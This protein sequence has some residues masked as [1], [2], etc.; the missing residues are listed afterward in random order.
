MADD[1]SLLFRLRGDA[2]GIRTATS[3][4]RAA[5]NQLKQSFGPEL[6]QSVTLA[7]KAFAG[8]SDNLNAF[9]SQRIPLVGNAFASVTQGL[10][11]LGKESASSERAIAGIAKSIQS[12]ATESG[13]SIPH[14]TSFL[15]K[16]VQIEG[17][18][19]RDKAAIDF[20]GASL[21]TKLVP[22]LEKTGAA[23]ATVST[24]SAGA[25]SAIAAIAGP[26][27]IAVLAFAALAAGAVIL[28]KEL[29]AAAKST[30]EFQ[31][32]LFDLSQQT[33]VSVET[34]SALELVARTTGSSVDALAQ[35]LGIFQ[36]KLEE[37]Q[38]PASKAAKTFRQ[39]GVETD[40]TE[41]SLRQAIAALARM[42]EGFRQ[43][44][45]ALEIFGRG[46]KAFLAI[47]KEA[48]G[49]IDE[50]TRRLKGLGLVTTEEAKLAD[51][52]NDQL[53]LLDIQMRGL[54]TEAIPVILDL[55]KDLSQGLKE[56]RDAFLVLQGVVKGLTLGIVVPLRIALVGLRT[57][58]DK[59][60][61]AIEIQV[62]LFERL[63]KAIGLIS[64]RSFTFP[65][66]S[67]PESPITTPAPQERKDTFA[68]ELN[69]EI[70]ARRKLQ[71]VL[72]FQFALRQQQAKNNIAA[73]QREFEAGKR[74]SE[75]L[76]EVI[77]TNTRKQVQAQIDQLEV[78]RGL[79]LK[80]AA[81]AKDDAIK[82]AELGNT[83]LGIDAQIATKRLELQRTEAD[84]RAKHRLDTQKAE[85]AQE[86]AKLDTL[87]RLGAERI[88]VIEEL[89]RQEKVN[90]EAGLKEI[91][92]IENAAIQARGQLLKRELELAG[93]GPDRQT[94]LDKIKS[95]ETDRTLLERQ[96]SERRKRIAREELEAKRQILS[97]EIDT[98]LEIEQIRAGRLIAAAE[99]LADARVITEENAAQRILA[100]RLRLI[101]SEVE[102]TKARLTAA[103]GISDVNERTRTEAEL[104]NRLR[105]LSEQRT[106]IQ[107]Q[108]NRDIDAGRQKDLDNERRYAEELEDLRERTI[109]AER[110]AAEEVIR[111]MV[112]SF[113][114]RRDIIRA[115]RD[116]QLQLE[117]D[118]HRRAT[119]RIREQKRDVDEEIRLLER[120]LERLK[121]GTTE[122]IEEHDRLIE[123][124]ERLRAKRAEL[125]AQQQSEDERNRDRQ[126]RIT[127]EAGKEE[128]EADPLGRIKTGLEDIKQFARELEATIVPMSQILAGAFDQISS[129]I[130]QTVSNW[131][132]LGETGPAVMRKIL[133][134]ALASIAAEAAVNAVKEL[135]LGFATLFFNPAESAGHFVAA[136]LWAS[137]A[138][139]S[140]I[141]GR[142][143]A[144]DLF[145]PKNPASSGGGRGGGRDER[146][147]PRPID[148]IR[149]Q[150]KQEL[151]VFV[152][153]EPGGRFNEAV[154]TA[155][156]DDVRSNGPLRTTIKEAGKD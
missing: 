51:E 56:N 27:G 83:I 139:G 132:L 111:L 49:D 61:F 23:L 13:K 82:Q 129:A 19:N 122:E 18:A 124:L 5:V 15:A 106:A 14:I 119:E 78:E 46:G 29:F 123:S 16:F 126:E 99:A 41:E 88:A 52:F 140:A 100:V 110:D 102:A 96:Q 74:A 133:A 90:R 104:N 22:E 47:A 60:K 116:L 152:H 30:A 77:I 103:A 107:E 50:I 136:G 141:A 39:L 12:I 138:G 6:T 68:E 135:A 44:A 63:A 70:E 42:P 25:G 38:D 154:V 84:L 128:D 1:L 149:E 147:E 89:L 76:L 114:R 109:D 150:L 69:D 117:D 37:A 75:D 80:E 36:R 66:I 58:F 148:L 28:S 64:G 108:G 98:L 156:I 155:S 11:G 10:R 59:A 62:A 79:R 54:A 137:I 101:D 72:N 34:L 105:V 134:Q 57:E 2:S 3:E 97:A 92:S 35:S 146:D 142:A 144:G 31:G 94:V 17:Q 73:A 153:A 43:T 113:A 67:T 87:S 21:G 125:D 81:A 71:G 48:N 4:A 7:N 127:I 143:V 40:D 86:Q 55:L 45:L 120:R 118:R 53:V 33:G 95:L 151:H 85:L 32:K 9:V 145:K 20:F 24:E 121:I 131:V 130:G 112:V 8:I 115:E 65:T 93:V 26:V 91:E